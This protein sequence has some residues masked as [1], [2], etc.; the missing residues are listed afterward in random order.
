M[1]KL[2]QIPCWYILVGLAWSFYQ[3][4]RG[5]IEHCHDNNLRNYWTKTWQKWFILYIH[6]FVFRFICSIAGFVSLYLAFIL[7]GNITN[8]LTLTTGTSV[9][10]SFLFLIGII[11]VG[12]QLH[13]V[14]LMGKLL[15][16]TSP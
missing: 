16:K 1:E 4:V 8:L 13:T 2:C 3:G 9:L 11:G 15:P 6:D 7:A 14:I 10:I 5:A 12:G